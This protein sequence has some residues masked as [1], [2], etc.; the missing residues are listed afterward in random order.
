MK[1]IFTSVFLSLGVFSLGYAQANLF[2]PADVDA[3]GW[4]WF[5]TPEKIDKYIGQADN[6]NS[7][8][9]EKGKIIQ[10]VSANFGEFVDSEASANF[11]GAGTD[12]LLGGVAAK[13]GALKLALASASMSTDGGGFI[14]KMPSCASYNIMLSSD[15]KVMCRMLGTANTGALFGDYS[16]ASAKYG[17]SFTAISAGQFT[18]ANIQSLTAG[19][20]STFKLESESTM[21]AYFQS[22][23]KNNI[24]IH[25]LK[26]LTVGGAS[27]E[28]TAN[29]AEF[30][31]DGKVITLA[32][33]AKV[34]VYTL[35]GTAAIIA[36][37]TSVDLS[38]LT[39]GVYVVKAVAGNDTYS[40]KVIIK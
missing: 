22:L 26:V 1:K 28:E 36:T 15:T 31:F 19:G 25:G 20:D 40:Q 7:K 4:I 38:N 18:W 23:T 2:D 10:L 29:N 6:E 27:I 32:K 34:S 5:D 33:D 9:D 14:V 12:K 37:G 39:S 21:Y 17:I 8:Y 11:I 30:S 16:V 3:E 13:N 24:Y 35:Q